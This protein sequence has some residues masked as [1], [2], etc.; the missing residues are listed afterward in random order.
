MTKNL[1]KT[2]LATSLLTVSMGAAIYEAPNVN[3]NASVRQSKKV[4]KKATHK[5]TTKKSIASNYSTS[6]LYFNPSHW[7]NGVNPYHVEKSNLT[8]TPTESFYKPFDHTNLT[9]TLIGV[10][11]TYDKNV[12]KEAVMGW[13]YALK[14]K[15]TLTQVKSH[16]DFSIRMLN[17][18]DSK[19]LPKTMAPAGLTYGNQIELYRDIFRIGFMTPPDKIRTTEHEIGHELGLDHTHKESDKSVMNAEVDHNLS[20]SDVASVLKVYGL[21]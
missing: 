1:F 10:K 18:N 5:K 17:S 11:S 21:K 9:Y 13:N 2:L 12:I 8:E 19:I 14:G 15:I 7:A 6:N 16:G 3:A 4:T 20:T